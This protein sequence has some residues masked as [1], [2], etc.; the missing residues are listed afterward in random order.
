MKPYWVKMALGG[1]LS[2]KTYRFTTQKEREAFLYGFDQMAGWAEYLI[3]EEGYEKK[4]SK[5]NSR[6]IIRSSN[7]C[8]QDSRKGR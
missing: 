5:K 8:N 7:G 6:S 3:I 1:E 4:E 2:R